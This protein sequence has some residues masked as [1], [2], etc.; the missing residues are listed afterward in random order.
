MTGND[1]STP[2]T[3]KLNEDNEKLNEDNE[4]AGSPVAHEFVSDTFQT[5][6]EGTKIFLILSFYIAIIL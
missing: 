3:K 2:V 6:D 4:V 1:E 5:P